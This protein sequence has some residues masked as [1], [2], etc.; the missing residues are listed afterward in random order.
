MS[1]TDRSEFLRYPRNFFDRMTGGLPKDEEAASCLWPYRKARQNNGSGIADM[2]SADGAAM[3]NEMKDIR[4]NL[5]SF[6]MENFLE[7]M[8]QMAM[9]SEMKIESNAEVPV[10]PADF[11]KILRKLI[12]NPRIQGKVYDVFHKFHR[13]RFWIANVIDKWFEH[14]KMMLEGEV[15][16]QKQN[17]KCSKFFA[18]DQGG[19]SSVARA[20]KSQLVKSYMLHMLQNAGWCIETTYKKTHYYVVTMLSRETSR[21]KCMASGNVGTRNSCITSHQEILDEESVDISGV[22]SKIIQE[23]GINITEEKLAGILSNHWLLPVAKSAGSLAS[24]RQINPTCEDNDVA[25]RL[26]LLNENSTLISGIT[27]AVIA[28]NVSANQDLPTGTSS[29][30]KLPL[31]IEEMVQEL[32]SPIGIMDEEVQP[33]FGVMVEEKTKHDSTPNLNDKTI[34]TKPKMDQMVETC[35]PD[36]V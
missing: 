35:D 13:D 26:L 7:D 21:E 11:K 6:I 10:T 18:T 36:Q 23:Y 9:R 19:F 25:G 22:A 32:R 3:L 2:V 33:P 4:E 12:N 16:I 27:E 14:E 24:P 15:R 30:E 8:H 5:R 17:G 34:S 28:S 20:V 31:I 1:Q 29:D